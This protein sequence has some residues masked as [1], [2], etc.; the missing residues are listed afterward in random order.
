[1]INWV[2]TKV[3]MF[4]NKPSFLAFEQENLYKKLGRL[5]LNHFGIESALRKAGAFA[6]NAEAGERVQ[7]LEGTHLLKAAYIFSLL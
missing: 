5:F 4:S 2:I 6:C 7:F 3:K 1:M